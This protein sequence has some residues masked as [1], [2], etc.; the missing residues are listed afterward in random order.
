VG[1]EDLA[2][3]RVA[4]QPLLELLARRGLAGPAGTIQDT[5][6]GDPA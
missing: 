1:G 6:G 2:A 3:I 5:M 4:A